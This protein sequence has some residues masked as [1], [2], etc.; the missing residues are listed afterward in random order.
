MDKLS[1]KILTPS[2]LTAKIDECFRRDF[3]QVY[4]EGE[5]SGCWRQ[6]GGHV[7]LYLSD[8][9]SKVKAIIWRGNAARAGSLAENGLQV[10]AR[11]RL[12]TYYARSEYQLIIEAME[13]RGEGALKLAFEK[14]KARLLAE[15]L[16]APERKRKIP[17]WPR[18]VAL[19]TSAQGAAAEDF[20]KT[21]FRRCPQAHISLFPVKVQ[22][23][24]A[25]LDMAAAIESVNSWGGFDLI[26]LTRGGG[27]LEDLWAFNEE[28]L[29]RA[30][31]KSRTLTF[32]AIGHS[33]DLSLT[34]M[35]SDGAAITPT[36]AAEAVFPDTV[37]IAAELLDTAG[38]IRTA[39]KN[40][41]VILAGEVSGLRRRVYAFS[42]RIAQER[43]NTENLLDK[44]SRLAKT[45]LVKARERL[46]ALTEKLRLLSPALAI[47]RQRDELARAAQSLG[48]LRKRLLQ[49][50][51]QELAHTIDRLELV[52][53]LKILT[54][55]YSLATTMKGAIV[56]SAASL[57]RGESF[58]L[59][60]AEG[61][62]LAKAEKALPDDDMVK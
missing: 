15:G 44:L 54:R 6:P 10:L 1:S 49:P 34:E 24:G 2:Q 11:G 7:Y 45:E 5:I 13:P 41:L 26:V 29:V 61:R 18:R 23:E 14:M 27:S 58:I 60:L 32:A 35:A 59:R 40:R 47:A 17:F 25:A 43:L 38:R 39:A 42:G 48:L 36:A 62:L 9:R 53:P 8:E 56:R 22:G 4:V 19:L 57:R 50:F 51:S 16:F 37:R 55:G 12:S 21:A 46:L 3:K 28:P 33:T 31:A 20:I 30:V 52:S